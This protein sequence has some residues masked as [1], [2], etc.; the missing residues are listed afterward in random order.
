LKQETS[1]ETIVN[2]RR[3]LNKCVSF[4][5]RTQQKNKVEQ[6]AGKYIMTW[7]KVPRNAS[8]NAEKL[9]K[10]KKANTSYLK[11][12][13]LKGCRVIVSNEHP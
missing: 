8:R 9:A 2:K 10:T 6:R 4:L 1:D 12:M 3:S 5:F 13:K 7:Q 11:K